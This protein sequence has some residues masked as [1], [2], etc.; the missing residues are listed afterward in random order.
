MDVRVYTHYKT[1]K[2]LPK[3]SVRNEGE[4]TLERFCEAFYSE[5]VT[6]KSL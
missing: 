4:T 5:R 3:V 6:K 2:K 1:T